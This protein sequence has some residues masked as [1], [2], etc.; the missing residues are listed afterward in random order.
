MIAPA[1]VPAGV[2]SLS[3][4]AARRQQQAERRCL[5]LLQGR[6]FELV[7]LPVLEY[8]GPGSAPAYR[9]VDPTGRVVAVRTDFTPL[10][11][12][13]LGRSLEG[14]RLPV[15]VCY[16]GEVVRPQ[17]TRLRR[18][19][20]LYQVGFESYGVEGG[21]LGTLELTLEL[22]A[23]LGVSPASCVVTVS[24]AQTTER[25]LAAVLGR[26]PQPGELELAQARDVDALA[27]RAGGALAAGEALE[28]ALWGEPAE[29]WAATLGVAAEVERAAPLLACARGRGLEAAL[30]AAPRLAGGYYEGVAFAVWGRATRAVLAAGGEY[31]VERG[32]QGALPAAGAS[33]TL[34]IVLEEA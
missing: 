10:A 27:E 16:A 25:I 14:A 18:L 33:L 31:R 34:G 4:A 30:D 6:G 5:D 17:P 21:G 7:Y 26:P 1:P 29:G 15:Q 19:P 32:G 24:V 12:R 13:V 9:F 22:L 11:A 8:A 23:E 2:L 28:A 20:E 3:G